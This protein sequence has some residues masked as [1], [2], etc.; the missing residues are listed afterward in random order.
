M[1]AD[2][3]KTGKGAT[4]S[5]AVVTQADIARMRAAAQVKTDSEVKNEKKIMEEQKAQ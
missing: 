1:R 2:I 5:A 3:E 4:R